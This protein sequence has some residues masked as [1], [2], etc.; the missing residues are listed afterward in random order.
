MTIVTPSRLPLACLVA[1]ALVAG[2]GDSTP[3]GTGTS[4]SPA[5]IVPRVD[6]RA[7]RASARGA[8]LERGDLPDGW[9]LATDEPDELECPAFDAMKA[10]PYAETPIFQHGD[11]AQLQHAVALYP[12]PAEADAAL[13]AL[14]SG[15]T[16]EC[17]TARAEAA[18]GSTA[19][20]DLLDGEQ[21]GD[22]GGALRLT[23]PIAIGGAE[24]TLVEDFEFERV[25]RGLSVI[26]VLTEET[27]DDALRDDLARR[28][29]ERLGDALSGR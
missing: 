20:L 10:A 13:D 24:Y 19:T 4:A 9:D 15:E 18:T 2:C 6:E 16:A 14:L 22:R 7:D 26:A 25:G 28:A 11:D 17:V 8:I 29:V 27:S 3:A 12:T 23:A 21:L 1:V 5:P